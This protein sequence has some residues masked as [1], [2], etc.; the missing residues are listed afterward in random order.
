MNPHE[1][2]VHR[3]KQYFEE[4]EERILE[5]IRRMPIEEDNQRRF[6]ERMRW[7]GDNSYISLNDETP[8]L[9]EGGLYDDKRTDDIYSPGYGMYGQDYESSSSSSEDDSSEDEDGG[10]EERQGM[11][12]QTEEERRRTQEQNEKD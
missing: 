11:Q 8:Y 5:Q 9:F 1:K 12:E 6:Y 2:T 10:G 3:R 7:L 4:H